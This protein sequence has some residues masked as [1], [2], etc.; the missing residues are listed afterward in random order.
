MET[1]GTRTEL[2][3]MLARTHNRLLDE[4]YALWSTTG[5]QGDAQR[6]STYKWVRTAEATAMIHVSVVNVER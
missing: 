1:F 4:G 6:V 5:E 2:I 3:N